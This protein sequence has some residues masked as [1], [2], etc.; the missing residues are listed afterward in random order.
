MSVSKWKRE[1]PLFWV[2]PENWSGSNKATPHTERIPCRTDMA[3]LPPKDHAIN[4][5]LPVQEVG[6]RS[7]KFAD[8]KQPMALWTW[9]QL[10][11]IEVFNYYHINLPT[12]RYNDFFFKELI[13]ITCITD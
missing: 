1:G 8:D 3:I 12:V 5:R 11:G 6:V 10:L 13:V 9:F 4:F 2:D 7:V